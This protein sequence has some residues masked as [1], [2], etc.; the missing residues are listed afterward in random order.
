MAK[1]KTDPSSEAMSTLLS[2]AMAL[3]ATVKLNPA[4]QSLLVGASTFATVSSHL[5]RSLPLHRHACRYLTL[6]MLQARL[7]DRVLLVAKGSAIEPWAIRAAET[8]RVPC[9]MITKNDDSFSTEPTI[10]VEIDGDVGRDELLIQLADRVD[11]I[12]VRP[13]GNIDD[14]LRLRLLARCD[15]TVRV[16][17]PC[18]PTQK[19]E[20]AFGE[21]LGL[22]AIG[23]HSSLSEIDKVPAGE[24]SHS[25]RRASLDWCYEDNAWLVHCTRGCTGPWPGESA[26]QY[27]DWVL[28]NNS[29]RSSSERGSCLGTLRRILKMR[30]LV[31]SALTSRHHLPVVCLS[32]CSLSS[33]LSRRCYR[34]HLHRW[35]YEP[36]GIAIRRQAAIAAGAAEVVYG[37]DSISRADLPDDQ[38]FRYQATGRTFDWT[39]EREWRFCGDLDLE[40]FDDEDIRV[41][42]ASETDAFE[43]QTR[44]PVSIVESLVG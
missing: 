4:A 10:N 16:A 26:D 14:A 33:L 38:Q 3:N 41:F 13:N 32:A 29:H 43:L 27:R 22:G 8:F 31:G 5:G 15:A 7:D 9:V 21:L 36:Y 42:V 19:A 34:S 20:R 24:S 39:S 28:L 17:T 23:W 18:E 25:I 11:C 40:Q 1:L 37:S 12:F 35:D 44:Y 2:Q 6:A 30:R